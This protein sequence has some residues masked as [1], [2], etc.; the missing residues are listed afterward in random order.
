MTE[1]NMKT[2]KSAEAQSNRCKSLPWEIKPLAIISVLITFASVKIVAKTM[3]SRC[4]LTFQKNRLGG[5]DCL[6]HFNKR[7]CFKEITNN[8]L[9]KMRLQNSSAMAI[10]W[11]KT[12][13]DECLVFQRCK[14]SGLWAGLSSIAHQHSVIF[15]LSRSTQFSVRS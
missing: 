1:P 13:S 14:N 2:V 15:T 7:R 4:I 8:S 5:L 11:T 10:C 12:I 3:K 6:F 9:C